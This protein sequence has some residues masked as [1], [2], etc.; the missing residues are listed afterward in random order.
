MEFEG[1]ISRV[2]P[3]RSG[4]S[5]AGNDFLALPFV[6][7]FFEDAN[8][9][10]SDKVLLETMDTNIMA[11]IGHYLKKGQDGKAVIENGECTMLGELKC[12]IGFS[13]SVRNFTRKDGGSGVMNNIWIYKF[14][15]L[16]QGAAV[17]QQPTQ[18][19]QQPFPPVQ[20]P[21]QN[22]DLPF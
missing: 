16:G 4:T 21:Q 22:D 12:K 8:Q 3:V 6:F 15:V 20:N 5:K 9:R 10:T 14:E 1:K 13:H 7:E 2:L 11:Q 19:M 18:Q 17:I